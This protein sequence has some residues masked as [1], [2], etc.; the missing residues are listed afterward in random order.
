[1]TRS[2][3][4]PRGFA[5][6]FFSGFSVV[7]AAVG[8]QRIRAQSTAAQPVVQGQQ[9][10]EQATGK[11]K[12]SANSEMGLG[13]KSTGNKEDQKKD[14]DQQQSTPEPPVGQKTTPSPKKDGQDKTSQTQPV[15][16]DEE[17]AS[18]KKLKLG[19]L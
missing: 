10:L 5:V 7:S 18:T 11:D 6:F 15:S 12:Q 1:M 8:P 17:A 19:P 2:F 3:L 4:R 14:Q 9:T 13:Q 16:P